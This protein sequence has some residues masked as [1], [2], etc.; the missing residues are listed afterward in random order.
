MSNCLSFVTGQCRER[1]EQPLGFLQPA[2]CCAASKQMATG[3]DMQAF[4]QT[5]SPEARSSA[6]ALRNAR[7]KQKGIALRWLR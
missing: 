7:G 5:I 3:E 1:D 6:A 4:M 2:D